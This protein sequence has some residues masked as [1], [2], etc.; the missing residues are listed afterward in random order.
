M[1]VWYLFLEKLL[2]QRVM[3]PVVR[4]NSINL[5][6]SKMALSTLTVAKKGLISYWKS[7]VLTAPL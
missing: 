5:F 6:K 2:F 3:F 4:K 1:H 7:A